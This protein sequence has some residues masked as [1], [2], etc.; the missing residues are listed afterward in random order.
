V[1]SILRTLEKQGLM[2][3]AGNWRATSRGRQLLNELVLRFLPGRNS[4]AMAGS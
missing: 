3:L 4:E 1:E 2:E